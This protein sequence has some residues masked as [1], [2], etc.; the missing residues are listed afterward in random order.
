MVERANAM[1]LI[2]W[3]QEPNQACAPMASLFPRWGYGL[4]A[5]PHDRNARPR[6]DRSPER[7][8]QGLRQAAPRGCRLP[9]TGSAPGPCV[10]IVTA[11]AHEGL[12]APR[13]DGLNRP[14][15]MLQPPI[16]EP[17]TDQCNSPGGSAP[18]VRQ[19]PKREKLFKFIDKDETKEP[20][21]AS[22]Y[23]L[24]GHVSEEAR[25]T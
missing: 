23:C 1:T 6:Q 21:S 19:V 11:T 20:C 4:G 2:G 24:A 8:P 3:G 7:Y 25:W 9:R 22:S 12:L 13:S 17:G 5:H 18:R 16:V 10:F 14:R 15:T